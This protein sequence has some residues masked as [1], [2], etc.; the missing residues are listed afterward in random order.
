[1]NFC[2]KGCN[3]FKAS[4]K[5]GQVSERFYSRALCESIFPEPSPRLG[6]FFKKNLINI[7]IH[8]ML[9]INIEIFSNIFNHCSC[10]FF[11]YPFIFSPTYLCNLGAYH[12]QFELALNKLVIKVF[13]LYIVCLAVLT[14]KNVKCL[15]TQNISIFMCSIFY[16]FYG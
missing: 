14:H 11:K 15:C 6:I 1:M 8:C 13:I 4:G 7:I 16:C 9:K 5:H 3:H 12:Y 2:T 10:S